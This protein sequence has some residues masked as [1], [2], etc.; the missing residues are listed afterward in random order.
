LQGYKS[1]H[2]KPDLTILGY[3]LLQGDS[4]ERQSL[5]RTWEPERQERRGE[6]NAARRIRDG[7]WDEEEL[8]LEHVVE[9]ERV[10]T[11]CWG[12]PS[13]EPAIRN[14]GGGGG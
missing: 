5:T 1:K 2:S 12:L 8:P 4:I 10:G 6:R 14:R 9:A 11:G 13:P 7:G 3:P